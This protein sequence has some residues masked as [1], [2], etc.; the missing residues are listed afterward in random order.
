M[1]HDLHGGLGRVNIKDQYYV[2]QG[3]DSLVTHA[4]DNAYKFYWIDQPY[5]AV[6]HPQ[7]ELYGQVTAEAADFLARNPVQFDAAGNSY[8]IAANP[9]SDIVFSDQFEK[10]IGVCPFVSGKWPTIRGMDEYLANLSHQLN[11]ALEVQGIRL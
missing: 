4:G 7:L 8:K 6:M 1:L 11:E 3:W 9:F 5:S 2:A 10:F